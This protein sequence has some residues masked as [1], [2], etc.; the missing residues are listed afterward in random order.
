[1]FFSSARLTNTEMGIKWFNYSLWGQDIYTRILQYW[2]GWFYIDSS[3]YTFL[4]EYGIALLCIATLMY[5]VTVKKELQHND[6]VIP[7]VMTMVS[8]ESMICREYFL[9]EY[10]V[11]LLA[12]LANIKIGREK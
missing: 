10:N 4:L 9:I 12:F 8:I 6:V 11:F 1:M 2:S 5:T 7:I 3:Y